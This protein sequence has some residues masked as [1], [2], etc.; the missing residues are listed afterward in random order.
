MG[1]RFSPLCD[2]S[3]Q[4]RRCTLVRLMQTISVQRYRALINVFSSTAVSPNQ[5][6]VPPLHFPRA[7]L[8]NNPVYLLLVHEHFVYVDVQCSSDEYVDVQCS[9][10]DC[11]VKIFN[12]FY[13]HWL[14]HSQLLASSPSHLP[15]LPSRHA[16]YKNSSW[17]R[18]HHQLGV[19]TPPSSI[20]C[21]SPTMPDV[22]YPVLGGQ[23]NTHED[24]SP[25]QRPNLQTCCIQGGGRS[26]KASETQENKE[27]HKKSVCIHT[28]SARKE[29]QTIPP[30]KGMKHSMLG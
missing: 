4:G 27:E 12:P 7:S 24:A 8:V 14:M 26:G 30:R 29:T 5:M 6:K 15:L 25:H 16:R 17:T 13:P 28:T 20:L 2:V 3:Y 10:D 23:A 1:R 19:R 22:P 9:S 11:L 21:G 18:Q